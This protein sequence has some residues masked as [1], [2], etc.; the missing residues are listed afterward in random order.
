MRVLLWHVHGSWT[1][2][3]VEGQHDYVVPVTPDR[4]PDGVGRARSWTW[5]ATVRELPPESLETEPFDVVI[6]QRPHEEE[7]AR[8]WLRRSP[9]V[10]L[11]AVYVEHNTPQ[12]DVPNTRHH[13]A[14]RP[15]LHLAHVTYFNALLWDSGT[16]PV[17]VIE[18]GVVDPGHRWTG[19]IE[20]AAVVV[21]EPVRRGRVTGTDLLPDFARAA[22]LDVF[23]MGTD[24]LDAH[25]GVPPDRL[26]VH[27][28][29]QGELHAALARRRAYLHPVRWTSLGLSLIEAMHLGMPIVALGT[30]AVAEAVPR[31]AG[32]VSTSPAVLATALTR[33]MRDHEEAADLG[34]A[35]RV[36]ALERYGLTRFLRDWDRLLGE[37]VG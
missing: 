26:R 4:G 31:E 14:D 13:I 28:L 18:H 29:S 8:R 24:L 17:S 25:L 5:P 7:L 30:T 21:N 27:N 32:V 6:L 19:E 16:T 9:G 22:P 1:T 35:A 36:A 10:D 12:L 20:R 37:V 2:A 34:A 15:E 3:F 33:L 11:P 23:G